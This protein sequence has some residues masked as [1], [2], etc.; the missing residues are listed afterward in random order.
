MVWE[1]YQKIKIPIIG[2][3]GIMDASSALEFFLAGATA[4]GVGTANFVNPRVGI[5]ITEG[6]KKYM[7]KNNFK[8][9]KTLRGAVKI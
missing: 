2:M 8:D 5:E 1:V 3:G 4:I 9:I 7:I 6:L